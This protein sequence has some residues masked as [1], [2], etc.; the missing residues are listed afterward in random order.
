MGS[1]GIRVLAMGATR[2]RGSLVG[3]ANYFTSASVVRLF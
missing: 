3:L 1:M 2:K